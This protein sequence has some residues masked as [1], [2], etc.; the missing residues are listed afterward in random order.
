MN[1]DDS[2]FHYMK[3]FLG[4]NTAHRQNVPQPG[5]YK[6]KFVRGS[7]SEKPQAPGSVRAMPEADPPKPE[8]ASFQSQFM[9]MQRVDKKSKERPPKK[10]SPKTR[11]DTPEMA[12]A[13]EKPASPSDKDD[14]NRSF[15]GILGRL[16]IKR[17]RYAGHELPSLSKRV[18]KQLIANNI[19]LSLIEGHLITSNRSVKS[20]YI[21]SSFFGEGR[22]LTSISVA[23]SLACFNQKKVLL[24]ET[25]ERN[26]SLQSLFSASTNMN[27]QRL[28]EENAPPEEEILPTAYPNFFLL[29][30]RE[31]RPLVHLDKFIQVVDG[32]KQEFDYLIIDGK[33]ILSSSDFFKLSSC[34]DGVII[35]VECE[36]TKWEVVQNIE[37][38]I[39][40]TQ[41]P[42][43][44]IILNKRKFYMPGGIYKLLT[45]R[46][47]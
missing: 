15:Q 29:P 26:P 30:A 18:E 46:Y 47:L 13:T 25:N 36:K 17:S 14:G 12:H 16:E 45:R 2:Q 41:V 24:V 10:K 5:T 21:S 44:G 37:E 1:K 8:T 32:L 35:V 20:V 27:I 22:T 42:Y 6:D 38:K 11:I 40:R 43:R 33:P 39:A 9:K 7:R 28:L 23:Y 4:G 31:K 34:L 19:Q 3:Q